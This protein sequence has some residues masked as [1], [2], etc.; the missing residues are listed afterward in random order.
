MATHSSSLVWEILTRSL[1]GYIHGV[2][3]GRTR[4]SM[5]TLVFTL[6]DRKPSEPETMTRCTFIR[7][8]LLLG[9]E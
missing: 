3:K 6:N 9:M 4:L 5:H 2:A 8:T 7:F 1:A